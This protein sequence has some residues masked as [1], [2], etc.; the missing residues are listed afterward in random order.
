MSMSGLIHLIEFLI[1]YDA[2]LKV[3]IL[4]I[5]RKK[6]DQGAQA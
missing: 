2:T 6:I 1:V 4:E 3:Q 5:I